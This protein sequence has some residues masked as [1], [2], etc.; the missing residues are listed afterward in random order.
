MCIVFSVSQDSPHPE[1]IY[2]VSGH[3][4]NVSK[5]LYRVRPKKT[6]QRQSVTNG[7]IE[8][9]DDPKSLSGIPTKSEYRK[10]LVMS[11]HQL[12]YKSR[13]ASIGPRSEIDAAQ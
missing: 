1:S 2:E 12:R 9:T 6:T 7:I 4:Q 13:A 3:S 5:N 8:P 11:P 10:R